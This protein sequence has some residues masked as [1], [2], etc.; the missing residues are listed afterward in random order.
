MLFESCSRVSQQ[1]RCKVSGCGNFL[2]KTQECQIC[3]SNQSIICSDF[4]FGRFL[5]LSIRSLELETGSR[6]N[7]ELQFQDE[8]NVLQTLP[9]G[10]IFPWARI[11]LIISVCYVGS[12]GIDAV[13]ADNCSCLCRCCLLPP[14]LV[15]KR[16]RLGSRHRDQK[17]KNEMSNGCKSLL[18]KRRNTSISKK[19]I[20]LHAG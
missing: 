7:D 10:C 11:K 18:K 6:M 3:V 12:N 13:G 1:Q 4:G 17:L 16:E 5:Q 20:P 9:D 8:L 14:L 15:K 19:Q 2:L